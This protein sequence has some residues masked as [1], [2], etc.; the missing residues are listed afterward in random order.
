MILGSNLVVLPS[1]LF[2]W[3]VF[4]TIITPFLT[5]FASFAA[6]IYPNRA[7]LHPHAFADFLLTGSPPPLLLHMT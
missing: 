5:F 2:C 4:Y 7:V 6:F 3:Q 1:I